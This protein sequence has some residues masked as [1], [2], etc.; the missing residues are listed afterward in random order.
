[1][2]QVVCLQYG[3]V[4]AGYHVTSS[5]LVYVATTLQPTQ[6]IMDTRSDCTY[7][8]YARDLTA[9]QDYL[10][11]KASYLN[12]DLSMSILNFDRVVCKISDIVDPSLSSGITV[13]A[14]IYEYTFEPLIPV[15]IICWSTAQSLIYS[16]PND[17]LMCISNTD[18]RNLIFGFGDCTLCCDDDTL[19]LYIPAPLKRAVYISAERD[20]LKCSADQVYTRQSYH[21]IPVPDNLVHRAREVFE[22]TRKIRVSVNHQPMHVDGYKHFCIVTPIL[23]VVLES[24]P[25]DDDM[26]T[27]EPV[28]ESERK[29]CVRMLGFVDDSVTTTHEQQELLDTPTWFQQ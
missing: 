1:V 28:E 26:D 21:R 8:R 9:S 3:T 4:Q 2:W 11:W 24:A 7:D 17:I 12:P 25:D 27:N 19:S 23:S 22:S 14:D 16:R 29:I 6:S 10:L 18:A 20:G 13:V 5:C 15:P